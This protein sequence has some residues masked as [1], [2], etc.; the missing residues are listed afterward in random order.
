MIK[1]LNIY[2]RKK[3]HQDYLE[4]DLQM[5]TGIEL[6]IVLLLLKICSIT[7]H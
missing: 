6:V 5:N 4:N 7:Q 1:D 2:K 3:M